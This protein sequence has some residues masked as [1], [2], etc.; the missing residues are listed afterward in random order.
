MVVELKTFPSNI[1]AFRKQISPR[2]VDLSTMS[3]ASRK[4]RD[5]C[6]AAKTWKKEP[7]LLKKN[8]QI[9][10]RTHFS[11]KNLQIQSCKA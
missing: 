2:L 6:K 3:A 11:S 9:F 10:V 8:R 4:G 1:S 7:F 5:F